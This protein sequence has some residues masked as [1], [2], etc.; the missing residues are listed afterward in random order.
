MYDLYRTMT[1]AETPLPTARQLIRLYGP[2][3]VS[4]DGRRP[5]LDSVLPAV[6]DAVLGS[7]DGHMAPVGPP[8]SSTAVFECSVDTV[9]ALLREACPRIVDARGALVDVDTRLV[10]AEWYRFA[11]LCVRDCRRVPGPERDGPPTRGDR[12]T[13]ASSESSDRVTSPGAKDG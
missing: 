2:R 10:F 12:A 13:S 1:V 8:R 3:F 7:L 6:L 9:V 4:A 5:S 11:L